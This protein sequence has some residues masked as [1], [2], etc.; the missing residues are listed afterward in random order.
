MAC[1]S[2]LRKDMNNP[3]CIDLDS[4]LVFKR[5]GGL[6]GRAIPGVG[7]AIT[8]S[9][10]WEFRDEIGTGVKAVSTGAG[11]YYNLRANPETGWMY[12]K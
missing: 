7:W 12:A 3:A 10:A 11:Y 9:D 2:K 4:S 1:I 6:V 8:A 5:L